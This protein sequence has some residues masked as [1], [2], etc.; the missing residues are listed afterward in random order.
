MRIIFNVPIYGVLSDVGG[1]EMGLCDH[2][3]SICL[4]WPGDT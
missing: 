4:P 2:D 3:V 1:G